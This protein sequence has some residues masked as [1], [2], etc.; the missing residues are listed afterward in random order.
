[1]E[2]NDFLSMLPS[3]EQAVQMYRDNVGVLTDPTS[4][5]IDPLAYNSEKKQI[6][7]RAFT[8]SYMAV[9]RV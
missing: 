1:M 2:L 5:G 9:R 6:R 8:S 3:L 4:F 7:G